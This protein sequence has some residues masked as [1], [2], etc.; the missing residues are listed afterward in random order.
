[1]LASP[2]ESSHKVSWRLFVSL[3][4]TAAT[5]DTCDVLS[6]KSYI[7]LEWERVRNNRNNRKSFFLNATRQDKDRNLR[8][9]PNLLSLTSYF[10]VTFFLVFFPRR[11][12][13]CVTMS[14]SNEQFIRRSCADEHQKV[15]ENVMVIYVKAFFLTSANVLQCAAHGNDIR[16]RNENPRHHLLN[17]LWLSTLSS[18]TNLIRL[19]HTTFRMLRQSN[20]VITTSFHLS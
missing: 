6:F 12:Q 16:A 15:W 14:Y 19:D 2:A 11:R 4:T 1:M 8:A 3:F 17:L 10:S 18:S 5:G 20:L 7:I 13:P 9:G